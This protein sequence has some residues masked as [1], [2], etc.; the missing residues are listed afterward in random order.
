MA[1][2]PRRVWA[3]LDALYAQLPGIDCQGLCA[4][5]CGP[6]PAGGMEQERIQRTAG[7]AVSAAPVR[8][9]VD[10]TL[11]VCHECS[12][13]VDGR[14]SVYDIRPMICR[15]WGLTEDMPCI[16]GCVPEGGLLSVE[17]GYAFL[18]EAF[19]V[20]GWPP[21][22]ERYARQEIREMVADPKRRASFI[23]HHRPTVAGRR[24][25]L[26]PSV[27]ERGYRVQEPAQGRRNG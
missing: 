17:E 18:A 15:L 26:P 16:Y 14:C 13:L 8:T 12:M 21:G 23:N 25:S 19:D 2:N 1:R 22:W 4:D 7:R 20:A 24:A 6:I 10:D 9:V 27:I 11:E 5:S 3:R